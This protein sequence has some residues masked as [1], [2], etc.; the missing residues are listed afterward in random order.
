MNIPYSSV[1]GDEIVSAR[2]NGWQLPSLLKPPTAM[3]SA[4]T[5][6]TGA[7]V[8]LARRYYA[9]TNSANHTLAPPI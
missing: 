4:P 3:A 5:V 9:A 7:S 2:V 1:I 6:T 8:T